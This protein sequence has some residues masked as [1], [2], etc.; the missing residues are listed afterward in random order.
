ME[1]L[2]GLQGLPSSFVGWAYPPSPLYAGDLHIQLHT[3]PGWQTPWVWASCAKVKQPQGD[4]FVQVS[5][6]LPGLTF[7]Y[8]I[9]KEWLFLQSSRSQ[10]CSSRLFQNKC[11]PL[12][13]TL[14]V[15]SVFLSSTTRAKCT[16][17][18][19]HSQR[20]HSGFC[21]PL[22]QLYLFYYKIN[23]HYKI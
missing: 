7:M 12:L 13:C 1:G 21:F 3:A 14:V 16:P 23:W 4:V 5:S 6:E 9:L 20:I 11:Y 18:V 17:A 19:L 8:L 22:P 15:H 2:P 10:L